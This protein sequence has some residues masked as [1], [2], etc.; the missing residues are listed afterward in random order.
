MKPVVR[1]VFRTLVGITLFCAFTD[2]M[3]NYSHISVEGRNSLF[4][5]T[6]VWYLANRRTLEND[7]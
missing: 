4:V 7:N 3:E 6:V 2:P 5:I 1:W